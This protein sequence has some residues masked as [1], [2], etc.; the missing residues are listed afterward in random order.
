[1]NVSNLTTHTVKVTPNSIL[2]ELQS[3]KVDNSV[4]EKIESCTSEKI[5]EKIHIES[6]LSDNETK[7]VKYL[8][9]KQIDIFSKGDSDIGECNFI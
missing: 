5:F 7:Q 6:T 3:V 2:C 1:M 9:T 8:L 4:F